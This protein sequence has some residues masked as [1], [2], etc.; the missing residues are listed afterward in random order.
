VPKHERLGDTPSEPKRDWARSVQMLRAVLEGQTYESVAVSNGVTRTSVERRIK[1]V[2]QR[3]ASIVGIQGVNEDGAAFVRR[4]RTHRLAVLAALDTLDT[5]DEL[6]APVQEGIRV[7]GEEEIAWGAQRIRARSHQPLED[8][9]LYYMLFATAARPLEIAR[10]QVHDYLD[11]QGQVRQISEVRPAVAITGRSRPLYFRSARL[12][13]AMTDYLNDRARQRQGFGI[14][15]QFRGLDPASRLFLSPSGRGFE[16]TP[17]GK[18][19]QK[20]F[21]CRAI[22]ETYRKLFRYAGLK[23]VTALTVRH[24]VAH[25]LYARGADE[26]QVGLLLGIAERSAV[27]EQFP[28][29]L[30]TLDDLTCEL[31]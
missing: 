15:G 21:L 5:L 14:D 1:S 26:S 27:R 6:S 19:G 28:R 17:Y 10:L 12:N 11:A 23:Q 22:Q 3:L 29:R 7:L 13:A 4:L 30:P 20:R 18:D 31:V 24:T 2:A 8:L 9:A 25:R 16:I